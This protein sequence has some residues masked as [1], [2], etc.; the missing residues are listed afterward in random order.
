MI[1]LPEPA[2]YENAVSLPAY[3]AVFSSPFLS[4]GQN[5][6]LFGTLNVNRTDA[7][8]FPTG[9][10]QIIF[11]FIPIW[12]RVSHDILP[13]ETCLQ[14]RS[15]H[16]VDSFDCFGKKL[17]G[18]KTPKYHSAPIAASTTKIAQPYVIKNSIVTES[19]FGSGNSFP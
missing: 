9:D 12:L 8:V 5:S 18:D 19:G 7:L 16:D 3:R 13:F 6:D 14:N 10:L 17:D 15:Q 11:P 1:V 2:F 4:H